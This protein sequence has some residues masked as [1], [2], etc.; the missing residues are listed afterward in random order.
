MAKSKGAILDEEIRLGS[1]EVLRDPTREELDETQSAEDRS[2]ASGKFATDLLFGRV[3]PGE[4]RIPGPLELARF[5]KRAGKLPR[6]PDTD[7]DS[8]DA[9]TLGI[10]GGSEETFPIHVMVRGSDGKL[11][12]RKILAHT[13]EQAQEVMDALGME[14]KGQMMFESE[15]QTARRLADDGYD[16]ASRYIG[17]G[18]DSLT[19][20]TQGN[21]ILATDG[22]ILR[23]LET[24]PGFMSDK[25]YPNAFAFGYDIT[26]SDTLQAKAAKIEAQIPGAITKIVVGPDGDLELF[27]QL[28]R[29]G[30]W[31]KIDN[32]GI[33]FGKGTLEGVLAELEGDAGQVAGHLFNATTALIML[34]AKRL[35]VWQRSAVAATDKARKAEQIAGAVK[36]TGLA[37]YLARAAGSALDKNLG[38]FVYTGTGIGL[39]AGL[40]HTIDEAIEKGRGFNHDEW[41]EIMDEAGIVFRDVW[42]M[43]RGLSVVGKGL[44]TFAT[45]PLQSF[46]SSR[47]QNVIAAMSASKEYKIPLIPPDMHPM[48]GSAWMQAGNL[49]ASTA[50][51]AAKRDA[52]VLSGMNDFVEKVLS[53]SKELTADQAFHIAALNKSKL[54]STLGDAGTELAGQRALRKHIY[55]YAVADKKLLNTIAT[56]AA[57]DIG[58]ASFSMTRIHQIRQQADAAGI[59]FAH[60][61]TTF[62]KTGQPILPNGKMSNISE[63]T[64]RL[65]E[66]VD[67]RIMELFGQLEGFE[68]RIRTVPGTDVLGRT[69]TSVDQLIALRQR[70]AALAD[71]PGLNSVSGWAAAAILKE[72]KQMMLNPIGASKVLKGKLRNIS[73][74]M[75]DSEAIQTRMWVKRLLDPKYAPRYGE[76]YDIAAQFFNLQRPEVIAEAKAMLTGGRNVPAATGQWNEIRLGFTAKLINNPSDIPAIIANKENHEALRILYSKSELASFSKMARDL[77]SFQE[78]P[79]ARLMEHS[80]DAADPAKAF[81]T[82]K[83]TQALRDFVEQ[84]GGSDSAQGRAIAGSFFSMLIRENSRMVKGMDV[85]DKGAMAKSMAELRTR[86]WLDILVGKERAEALNVKGVENALSMMVGGSNMGAGLITA[87]VTQSAMGGVL[88][89]P[90]KAAHGWRKWF[91]NYIAGRFL[92]SPSMFKA[93]GLT[94]PRYYGSIDGKYLVPP[95]MSYVRTFADM[96]AAA[97]AIAEKDASDLGL[98]QG[99]SARDLRATLDGGSQK[100]NIRAE[101]MVPP[102]R[103]A[104]SLPGENILGLPNLPAPGGGGGGGG[105]RGIP[106]PTLGGG[107][108]NPAPR[109]GGSLPTDDGAGVP[110]GPRPKLG[111]R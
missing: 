63:A 107:L 7:P 3:G 91:S 66:P 57:G 80:K 18:V 102:P 19:E 92:V 111:Q 98:D 47:E 28:E 34:A 13:K 8:I 69:S 86:G 27:S 70:A 53:G 10:G 33:P 22:D 62:G 75:D 38:R 20:F 2:L 95:E 93:A 60:K 105:G 32:P 87:S 108:P 5:E 11:V 55:Q 44:S 90:K 40:G 83:N 68:N 59:R 99:Y 76:P 14:R 54:L 23:Q 81:W 72:T 103:A 12:K 1:G 64:S 52:F 26:Q 100:V 71:E 56:D 46:F 35:P 89:A 37:K 61:G 45:K 30:R 16:A 65:S 49:S 25:G 73:N 77:G 15:I 94:N 78:G 101:G 17:I 24:M 110:P 43:D 41:Q 6:G 29:G 79:M 104:H 31:A 67:S 51:F 97:H 84:A 39:S 106:T 58:K 48:F 96:I 82:S 36:E 109:A 85:L 42:L 9:K 74:F 88:S 4:K 50:Q 21:E